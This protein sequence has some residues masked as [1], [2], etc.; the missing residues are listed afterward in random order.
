MAARALATAWISHP[1]FRTV[2][3]YLRPGGQPEDRVTLTRTGVRGLHVAGEATTTNGP[4]TMHGAW[5]SGEAAAERVFEDFGGRAGSRAGGRAVVVGAGLAGLAAGR[6]L[7]TAGWEVRVLEADTRIGGRTRVDG[8]LGGPVHLGAAWVHGHIGNPVADAVTRLG[9]GYTTRTWD[10]M[11]T[12]VAG[13]GR[14]A[15][16]EQRRLERVERHI[17]AALDEARAAAGGVD[18]LGPAL[19][20]L[21]EERVAPGRDRTVL[22]CWLRGEYENLYAAP[23]DDLSLA[24]SN[25]PFR[26][27]GDDW[28]VTGSLDAV[29]ADLAVGLEITTSCSVTEVKKR[30]MGFAVTHP[31]GTVEADAVIVAVPVGVLRAGVI[32]FDPPLPLELTAAMA[33]IGTGAVAKVFVAY[34]QAFWKPLGAFW[35]ARDPPAPAELFVD[36]SALAGRPVLC[37]FAVGEHARAVEAKT[38]A[39]LAA[40]VDA[41]L[42]EAGALQAG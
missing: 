30:D 35:V 1:A 42:R 12:F 25:E 22:A 4:A 11:A 33:R 41:T 38:E 3:S 40:M 9:L 17:G 15:L 37:G 19:R 31:S 26:L 39:E 29:T 6:R 32:A 5:F 13:H 34:E 21:L 23:L 8:S 14:L 2:Y 27:P 28:M 7:L 20:R 10:R 16:A 36:V 18:A 24:H